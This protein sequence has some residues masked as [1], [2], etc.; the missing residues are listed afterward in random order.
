MDGEV[1]IDGKSQPVPVDDES[2]KQIAELSGGEFYKAASADE[3]HRV[4]DTLGE[5]IGY[6]TKDADAS[7]ALLVGQRL[8]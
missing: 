3:L 6:E 2:M 4:Y 8:P 7:S 1:T 5:Q